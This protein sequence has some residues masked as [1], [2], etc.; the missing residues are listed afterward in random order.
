MVH[1]SFTANGR[2][3]RR[4]SFE[5]AEFGKLRSYPAKPGERTAQGD[6]FDV[7]DEIA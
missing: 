4:G 1:I 3:M 5:L 6:Y 2:R 7:F